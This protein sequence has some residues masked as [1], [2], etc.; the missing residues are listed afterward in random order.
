MDD[1]RFSDDQYVP[2]DTETVYDPKSTSSRLANF[3]KQFFLLMVVI[4]LIA[5]LVIQIRIMAAAV[6]VKA[7]DPVTGEVA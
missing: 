1:T 6:E 5:L 3:C 7:K 4:G 2:M